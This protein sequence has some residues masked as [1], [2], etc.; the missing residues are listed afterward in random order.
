MPADASCV[1]KA[2]KSP[3]GFLAASSTPEV[4]LF[5]QLYP[6]GIPANADLM[7]ELVRAIREGRLSLRPT[8]DTGWYGHQLFALETLLVTDKSE[9]R[10]KVAFTAK[11][12]KRLKEAFQTMLVQHR[13]THAKQADVAQPT[14][15]AIPDVPDFRVEPLATVY[16]R[17]ARSYV[18][19]EQALDPILGDGWLDR[20]KAF[21]DK[22]AESETLRARIHHARDLFYGLY[23]TASQDIGL[24][25]TLDQTGDPAPATWTAL[26]SVADKWL[27]GLADDPIAKHDVRVMIP[28]ASLDG[29]RAKYWAVIGVRATLAAY[30]YLQPGGAPAE[31]LEDISRV[32][33]PTEQFI[34]VISSNTPLDRE[35]FR[36]LCDQQ[37]TPE[38][39]KAALAAR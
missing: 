16:V 24:K 30:S 31:K 18:F 33:L 9:E 32:P 3:H 8:A 10:R 25:P 19:L 14:S 2:S 22:G 6:T 34:E 4:A 11:Y 23:L 26:A 13:E 12:K 17:H 21:G 1:E 29:G 28:I 7:E 15:I 37:K 36:A 38:A 20:A 5:E 27:L 35:E 39:I